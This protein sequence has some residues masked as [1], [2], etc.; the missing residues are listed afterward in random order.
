MACSGGG[1]EIHSLTESLTHLLIHYLT[2]YLTHLSFYSLTHSLTHSLL[3]TSL[4]HYLS[5]SLTFRLTHIYPLNHPLTTG[6]VLD[7]RGRYVIPPHYPPLPVYLIN[8]MHW[9]QDNAQDLSLYLAAGFVFTV[10]LFLLYAALLDKCN[11]CFGPEVRATRQ[12]YQ[13]IYDR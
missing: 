4:T 11:F 3:T 10:V 8:L 9:L 2:N 6:Y 5:T 1:N 13:P 7:G 12:G